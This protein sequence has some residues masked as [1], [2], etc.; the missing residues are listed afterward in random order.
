MG[1][2]DSYAEKAKGAA[3]Q[4]VGEVT[5]SEE[6]QEEGRQQEQKAD[7]E[8]DAARLE[9]IAEEK[10]EEAQVHEGRERRHSA[11]RGD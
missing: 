11:K 1:K 10:R 7:A 8:L 6:L 4:A 5:G 9:D 2:L 3:K